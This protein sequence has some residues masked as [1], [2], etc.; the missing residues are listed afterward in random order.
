MMF[1]AF[2]SIC[3]EE[4]ECEDENLKFDD[5]SLRNKLSNGDADE[6]T[7]SSFSEVRISLIFML[8]ILLT[9]F[10]V[11]FFANFDFSES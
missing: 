3:R 11:L 1:L 2:N 6:N 7:K 5:R 4:D 9:T 8:K 10:D